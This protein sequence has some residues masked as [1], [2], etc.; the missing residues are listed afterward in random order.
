MEVCP[1]ERLLYSLIQFQQ[2]S[3]QQKLDAFP[4]KRISEIIHKVVEKPS[5]VYNIL[6]DAIPLWCYG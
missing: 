4:S 5:E 2:Y 3:Q 6:V 1:L